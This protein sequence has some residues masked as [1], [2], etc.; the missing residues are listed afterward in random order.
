MSFESDTKAGTAYGRF[1]ARGAA[2]SPRGGAIVIRLASRLTKLE[3]R[4]KAA[5]PVARASVVEVSPTGQVIGP[6]PAARRVMMTTDH[7]SDAQWQIALARN[8]A[9]LLNRP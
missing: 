4:A 7:G 6:L 5:K 3:Q 2:R 8:Q 9:Q 1:F